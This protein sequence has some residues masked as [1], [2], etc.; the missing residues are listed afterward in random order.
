VEPT[1]PDPAELAELVG[2]IERALSNGELPE[3]KAVMQAVVA[4]IK[5]RDRGQIQPVFPRTDFL[6]QRMAWCTQRTEVE[7]MS[8]GRRAC[9][10]PQC[11]P[12][13]SFDGTVIADPRPVSA[14]TNLSPTSGRS[15]LTVAEVHGRDGPW[16]RST[17]PPRCHPPATLWTTV[18]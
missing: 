11:A 5:V 15:R 16:P 7:K 14:L 8:A 1:V 18:A 10:S 12:R 4:E 2:D 3:R 17:F 13:E 9:P 6:D